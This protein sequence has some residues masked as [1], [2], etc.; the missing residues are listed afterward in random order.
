MKIIFLNLESDKIFLYVCSQNNKPD[1]QILL[2]AEIYYDY[3]KKYKPISIFKKIEIEN[4]IAVDVYVKQCML[5]Y[6]V[7]N[8]RGGSYFE[9]NIPDT[10]LHE[11]KQINHD[12]THDVCV[13]NLLAIYHKNMSMEEIQFEK[14]RLENTLEKY[15]KEKQELE[16]I[17]INGSQI[18][19]DIRWI[20]HACSRNFEMY[21]ANKNDGNVNK[22]KNKEFI[23]KYKT[24][25][26]SLKIIYDISN[27][28]N[29]S[30]IDEINIKY[31]HFLLDDIFYHW[32]RMHLAEY[33]KEVE[34]ICS[35][36]EDMT[37]VIMLKMKEIQSNMA[38]L[39]RNGE[40]EDED[41]DFEWKITRALYVLNKKQQNQQK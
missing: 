13:E 9:E 40:D 36:Y 41:A 7:D 6:G 32:H 18:I 26:L 5:E 35:I 2:E 33:M 23:T 22:M 27:D 21:D 16:K 17:S 29:D 10:L 25:L 14:Q 28:N 15:K 1:A 38:T 4:K 30:H 20:K 8:V 3:L 37:N 19:E 11:L 34:K 31:P 39:S 12:A 24:V